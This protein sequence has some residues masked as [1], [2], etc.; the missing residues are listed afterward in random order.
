MILY[1]TMTTY[2]LINRLKGVHDS[3]V[4][5]R[6]EN[7]F[8][9][10]PNQEY[11]HFFQYAEHAFY[12]MNRTYSPYV[13][14]ARCVIPDDVIYDKGFGYYGEVETYK[15]N[16]LY[17]WYI[18]LPEYRLKKEDFKNAYIQEFA[19]ILRTKMVENNTYEL[20]LFNLNRDGI[21]RARRM[22]SYADMYYE[23][24]CSLCKRYAY[25]MEKIIKYLEH[26]ELNEIIEQYY[27]E[28]KET[29]MKEL[30][31]K[32]MDSRLGRM[33]KKVFGLF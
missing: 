2:E 12:Y 20:P 32:E 23:L 14:V 4:G 27:Q 25:D 16:S 7:T 17:N 6:G 24:L 21:I 28:N 3:S 11:I 15:N 26:Q 19:N 31:E 10:E 1:R 29:L 22:Y 13:I 8:Y 33:K 9:Y 5:I 30:E 18:P